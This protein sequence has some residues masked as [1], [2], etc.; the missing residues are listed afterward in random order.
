MPCVSLR[1]VTN[2]A[3]RNINLTVQDGDLLVLM[4]PTGAGKTTLLNVIAGLVPY[5]GSVLFDGTVV[6]GLPTHKRNI[7]YLFQDF[8]LFPHLDVEENIAFG[9]KAS[10]KK[11]PE[12]KTRVK[13]TLALLGIDRLAKRY[14]GGLSGGEKQRVALARALAPGPRVFLLDEPFSSLDL[15]TSK[16]LRMEF[17]R[18][19]KKL[20]ITTL[21]VTHNQAEAFEM[22]DRMAVLIDGANEQTGT[23]LEIFF[24]P[25]N[26]KVSHLWGSPNIFS[27]KEAMPLDQGLARVDLASFSVVVPHRG[28]PIDKIAVFPWNIH[29]SKNPPPGPDMNR[30]KG[31]V[32]DVRN[33]PPV[34]RAIVGIGGQR[35]L[36]EVEEEHWIYMGFHKGEKVYLMV[37]LRNIITMERNQPQ[38]DGFTNVHEVIET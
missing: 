10:G 13:E 36:V 9:L 7:G 24:Q 16:Y 15:P 11:S 32:L 18:L 14:P 29:I 3:C 5:R 33:H 27:C 6:D 19:Q 28:Q 4:G 23:P 17:R 26:Q 2:Y 38:E 22:A 37:P 21:Y 31:R 20:G 12:S 30:W 1:Q 34:V 25:K 35:I 8:F